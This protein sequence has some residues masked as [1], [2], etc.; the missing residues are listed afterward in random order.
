MPRT[1]VTVV[2]LGGLPVVPASE[3]RDREP[4]RQV[5]QRDQS[6]QW[7][8]GLEKLTIWTRWKGSLMTSSCLVGTSRSLLQGLRSP[9]PLS[10]PHPL[11]ESPES[12]VLHSWGCSSSPEVAPP[13]AFSFWVYLGA[14][15]AWDTP[16]PLACRL[17]NLPAL[18]WMHDFSCF[19]LCWFT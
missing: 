13:R 8:Q 19:N 18:V 16:S 17:Y 10:Q 7:A 1:Q 12:P 9:P 6:Y 15:P 2:E 14:N 5:D 4:S 11:R 3:G